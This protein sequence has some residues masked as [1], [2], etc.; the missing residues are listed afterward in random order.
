MHRLRFHIK[1]TGR[2]TCSGCKM[3]GDSQP[4][5]KCT[6]EKCVKEFEFYLHQICYKAENAFIPHTPF[7]DCEFEYRCCPLEESDDFRYCD[8]CG[9]DT[10]GFMRYI[11]IDHG[12]SHHDLHPTCANL[13]KESTKTTE[14]G[15][16]LE[17][18]DKVRSKCRLCKKRY[19]VEACKRFTGWKWVSQ[20]Y[21]WSF[22][23]CFMGRKKKCYHLKCMN[24]VEAAR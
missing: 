11:C 7:F 20:K 8:A 24:L 21:Y 1:P 16:V 22:S 4:Y 23:L 12:N 6:H 3:P 14:K 18:K 9:L 19:P 10:K 2:Y 5:L 15:M 13:S 17:L